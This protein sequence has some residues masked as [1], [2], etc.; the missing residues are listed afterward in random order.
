MCT[1]C[2]IHYVPACT[3]GFELR[4]KQWISFVSFVSFVVD[5]AGFDG[6][7]AQRPRAAQVKP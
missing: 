3:V 2:L 1:P 4:N 6:R 7:S 5:R